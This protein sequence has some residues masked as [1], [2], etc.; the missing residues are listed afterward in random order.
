MSDCGPGIQ[1]VMVQPSNS[2]DTV[3]GG[4]AIALAKLHGNSTEDDDDDFCLRAE[5]MALGLKYEYS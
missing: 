1:I 3:S 5:D 2:C 4:A